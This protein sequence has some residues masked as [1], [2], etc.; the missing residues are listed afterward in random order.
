MST[1]MWDKVGER[2]FEAG[3]DRGVLYLNGKAY[4]WN[5]LVS[6][7]ESTI[8]GESTPYYIDGVKYL[9][10]ISDTEFEATINA[11]TYPKEFAECDGT[12]DVG[13]GF[14]VTNQERSPFGLSYRTKI[15]ND[16]DGLDHGY[17]IH[18]VY[19]A[20]AMPSEVEYS[21]FSD[22]IEPMAFSW[23]IVTTPETLTG[24]RPT[25]HF[26]IDSIKTDKLHLALIEELLYGGSDSQ[27]VPAT[28][29]TPQEILFY[30]TTELAFPGVLDGGVPTDVLT[31]RVRDAGF[32]N[33]SPTVFEDGG[34]D[35][36]VSSDEVTDPYTWQIDGE[37]S[38]S[39]QRIFTLDGGTP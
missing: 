14:L 33:D 32:Y 16:V 35:M 19:N 31:F 20:Y 37:L 29:P 27:A 30:L 36:P 21:T 17:K 1:L 10:T 12:L 3:V 5:G 7:S 24:Y 22:T 34:G 23:S 25:A 15:G 4:P 6:V 18:L 26:V 13:N 39:L 11:F 9:T 28:L 8:G 2:V 38:S